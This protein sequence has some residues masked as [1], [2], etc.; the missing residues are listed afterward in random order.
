MEPSEVEARPERR[1]RVGRVSV[2]GV[3]GEL[4]VTAGVLVFLFLGWQLWLN[5]ILVGN[6]QRD[7][8]VALSESL[9]EAATTAPP[10]ETTA[11]TAPPVES[12]A[13]V[14]HGDPPV[15]T[16]A[17]AG[18]KAFAT[19]Y[20]PR[21]GSDY[22]RVIAEGVSLTQVL[23][24]KDLGV[25]HYPETQLPGEVGNFALAAHRTTWGAPFKKVGELQVGDAIYVQTVDGWYTYRYRNLEY[26]RP[27]G[28]GVI[29]PIPQAPGVAPGERYITLTS[30]NPMFSAAERIVAYGVL[31]AW[32]P[33]SAG[34]PAELAALQGVG[35]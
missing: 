35:A 31:E 28:V 25:G 24:K 21:F 4:F 16:V 19:L 29:E 11:P 13:S 3:L 9:S 1:S 12:D 26:V 22:I 23:N 32:Q 6:E 14:D 33:A 2:F 30:C 17:V 10:A 5:D 8:A 20:I 7:S 18:G 15:S 27:T 34:M